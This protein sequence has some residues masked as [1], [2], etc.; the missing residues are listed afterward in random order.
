MGSD[1]A[2]MRFSEDD[3][4]VEISTFPELLRSA[5]SLVI[6][7]PFR[8]L[9]GISVKVIFLPKKILLKILSIAT[10]VSVAFCVFD[11]VYSLFVN[12]R[13]T[14]LTD[15]LLLY[16]AATVILI[17]L[18]TAYKNADLMLY[19]QLDHMFPVARS[20]DVSSVA[21]A[22]SVPES[23]STDGE[24]VHGV[25]EKAPINR[26]MI[27]DAETAANV[28]ALVS[29][30]LTPI[31]DSPLVNTGQPRSESD[32]GSGECVRD[33][34]MFSEGVQAYANRHEEWVNKVLADGNAYC[35]A[36]SEKEVAA[37]SERLD[38]CTD[39][40]MFIDEKLIQLFDDLAKKEDLSVLSELN[41]G[42][43]PE[44]FSILT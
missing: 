2:I 36:L 34:S 21:T 37:F 25:E 16:I 13:G 40:S 30:G 35:G 4:N 18:L 26:A 39:P 42:I 6:V 33:A 32:T 44:S 19:E 3:A 15:D 7:A 29:R 17:L 9:H 12:Y 27:L 8:L 38:A 31:T 10:G 43:I 20:G 1:T 41:I 5:L 24:H 14:F 28:D 22:S 23:S 11:V